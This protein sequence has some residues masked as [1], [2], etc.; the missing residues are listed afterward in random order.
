VRLALSW[1]YL[2]PTIISAYEA[3]APK[4][5]TQL[6]ERQRVP[7]ARLS[8]IGNVLSFYF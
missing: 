5:S 3:S 7:N 1:C 2:E 4:C 6:Q 8:S